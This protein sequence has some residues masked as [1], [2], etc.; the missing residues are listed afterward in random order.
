MGG[1]ALGYRC[2]LSRCCWLKETKHKYVKFRRAKSEVQMD[3]ASETTMV[4]PG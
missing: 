1:E 4:T 2:N 3:N